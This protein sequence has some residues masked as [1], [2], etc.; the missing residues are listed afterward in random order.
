MSERFG[1]MNMEH[2]FERL[3]SSQIG[4]AIREGAVILIPVGQ[5]EEH[6]PHLPVHTDWLIADELSLEAARRLEGEIRVL[7]MT[8][9][10]YGYSTSHLAKWPGTI[11]LRQETVTAMGFD[12]C[13]SLVEMGFRRIIFVSQHGHHY[14]LMR[15]L[16]RR[17]WDEIETDVAVIFP[18]GMAEPSFKKM[19]RGGPG[20]SCH[21]CELETSLMLHIAPELVDM[22]KAPRGDRLQPSAFGSS[23]VFWS[24]WNRQQS[25]SGAY[26]E[27]SFATVE[28]GKVVFDAIVSRM[29]EFIREYNAKSPTA[30]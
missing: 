1:R 22:E 28:T 18:A 3:S 14:G 11:R 8:G 4:E 15:S 20:S 21:A 6:G 7:A 13:R 24:T 23:E 9:I 16:A 10:V 27:P 29:A 2:R 25:V 26:G 5:V 30:R 12:I 19:C 17:I